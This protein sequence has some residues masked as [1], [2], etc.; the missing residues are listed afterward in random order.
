MDAGA[1]PSCRTGNF[2]LCWTQIRLLQVVA[3]RGY[4]RA[5]LSTGFAPLVLML[6]TSRPSH[7]AALTL[8]VF[9]SRRPVV[10]SNRRLQY[11]D[12]EA[13][14]L[15]REHNPVPA[16]PEPVDGSPGKPGRFPDMP[17]GVRPRGKASAGPG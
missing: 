10:F 3:F 7:L 6:R 16:Y 2:R 9:A 11:Q 5:R 4:S 8:A 1:M 13:L 12:Q 14:I 17:V 15:D